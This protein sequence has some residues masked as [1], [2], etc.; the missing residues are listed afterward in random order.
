MTPDS[1]AKM[2]LLTRSST[3]WGTYVYAYVAYVSIRQHIRQHTL[4][5]VSIRLLLLTR[6]STAWGTY[7]YAYVYVYVYIYIY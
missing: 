6:S 7:V 2:L 1:G 3:A 4:A 5:Y